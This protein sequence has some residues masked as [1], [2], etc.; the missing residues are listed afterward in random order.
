MTSCFPLTQ[1]ANS[2][3]CTSI[4]QSKNNYHSHVFFGLRFFLLS[5]RQA[6]SRTFLCWPNIS[7]SK[8]GNLLSTTKLLFYKV[9]CANSIKLHRRDKNKR[10]ENKYTILEIIYLLPQIYE[11]SYFLQKLWQPHYTPNTNGNK[12]EHRTS[13]EQKLKKP[14]C[15]IRLIIR[16]HKV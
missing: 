7:I 15:A 14:F 2:G 6:F 11:I 5:V 4:T 12:L 8:T 13:F 9:E 1:M 16:L 3:I 10:N